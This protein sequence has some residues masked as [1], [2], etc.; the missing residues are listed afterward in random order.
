LPGQKKLGLPYTIHAG[1]CGSVENVELAVA[2]G[3]K[4]I[5]HGI[6]LRGHA[7]AIEECVRHN[8]AIEMC[9]I[10]NLQTKAST[11]QDYPMREFAD[12]GLIV[13]VNTDNRTV[14]N[15]SLTREL[16]HIQTHYGFSDEEL[17][18]FQKNAANAAFADDE[19]RSG[20]LGRLDNWH[21]KY[22]SL[23]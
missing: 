21:Y 2:Y 5:G 6:A 11:L 3:A 7:D 10:S 4:R 9:P 12:A 1:E 16:E 22:N 17:Y 14:S 8:I 18:T 23:K 13:T 15:T 19:T 20:L